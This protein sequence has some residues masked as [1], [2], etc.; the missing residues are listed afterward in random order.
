[1]L[2]EKIGAPADVKKLNE[3]QLPALCDEIRGVLIDTVSK[4]GGHLASNLGTVELTVAL[5]R[6]FDCPRDDILFDV[7][8]QCYT[9]KLLTGRQEAFS[10]L[11]QE[12]GLSGFPKPYESE[13]DP[14][15]VGHSSTAMSSAIGL[16][17][18]KLLR[19]DPSKVIAVVGDGSFAGGMV[20]E[21]INSIDENL[22]NLIVVLNDNSMSISKSVGTIPSYLLRLRT[23]TAYSNLKKRVQTALEK[24]P[25]IGPPIRDALLTSKS[26]IRRAVYDGTLFE[27]LGFHYLG[28]VDGHD[29]LELCRI[30][31]NI[32]NLDGPILLHAITVK[33]KGYAPAEEN[34]GA[35]HGVGHFDIEEGNPDISLSDSYSNEFGKA[36]CDLGGTDARICAVTA[37]MKYGTGLQ[38]FYKKHKER[39]FDAGIAEQHAATFCAGLAKG[40]LKP[41][42]AVY[43]TFLQRAFDQ[44]SQDIYIN[45]AD[46]LLAIDRAGLV[47]EDGETHQGLYDVALLSVLRGF[48][49]VSPS[50]YA[51]LRHWLGRL[52]SESGP[53]AIRYPRGCEDPR[54]KDYACSGENFDIIKAESPADTLL[55]TYGREFAEVAEARRALGER[56]IRCDI[57]KLTRILPLDGAAVEAAL[58][59]RKVCFFEESARAGGLGAQFG[60]G[61]FERGFAGSYSLT[62][63]DDPIVQQAS[64][65]AQLR[66][67]GLD[68]GSI[69][70]KVGGEAL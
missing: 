42:F 19:G 68:A 16:A 13:C 30:L 48:V 59:Y 50:N 27:E 21:A 53:R 49:C 39:F 32:R 12:N 45:G 54:T 33:G 25:V 2:L 15:I 35:Y 63:V 52:L 43:S 38:Y 37:A 29:V 62:A 7:G 9:H 58:P 26:F 64:V 65:P 55:V 41:V 17:R 60:E 51:E 70:K 69:A 44:L 56:G 20:Y 57:L 47:G 24:M 28:P 5:H 34:P 36:L 40:G 4:T 66:R 31:G 1:M 8:H 6:V 3:K 22:K 23:G 18:A 46:V 61:L 11:R 67:F 14:F 10:T